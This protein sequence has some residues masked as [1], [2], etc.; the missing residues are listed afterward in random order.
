MR[1]VFV[2]TANICRSPLAEHLLR[3]LVAERHIEGVEVT[4]AGLHARPGTEPV[5]ALLRIARAR[6]LDL[7]VHRA[8]LL[9]PAALGPG[10][11]VLVMEES[12]RRQI[13]S[14]ARVD[15][16]AVRLLGRFVPGGPEEVADPIGGPD[17][18]YER[19]YDQLSICLEALL[20]WL[21]DEKIS[22]A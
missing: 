22:R 19:C 12:H 5:E 6:G 16:R 4:S 1:I 17:L 10:D 15:P 11:L 18:A 21:E 8:R 3:R 14:L 2:C 7:S 20:V 13:L 9:D